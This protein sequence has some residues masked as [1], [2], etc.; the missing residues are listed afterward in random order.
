M[1]VDFV[2]CLF[3]MDSQLV[4]C[5]IVRSHPQIIGSNATRIFSPLTYASDCSKFVSCIYLQAN[6]DTFG[7]KGTYWHLT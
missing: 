6:C 3:G 5:M 1:F 4:I 2:S 7:L